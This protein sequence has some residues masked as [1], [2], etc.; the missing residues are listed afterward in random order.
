MRNMGWMAAIALVLAP[1]AAAQT[2]PQPRVPVPIEG[3]E[4]LDPCSMGQVVGLKGRQGFLALRTAPGT[5][6]AMLDRL[7]NGRTLFVCADQGE[8]LGVVYGRPGQSCG[9]GTPWPQGKPYT[10]P[11]ASGWVHRRWVKIIAG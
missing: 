8:W 3:D 10:G 7:G 11:C 9:V 6:A 1:A 5:D 4:T 2:V